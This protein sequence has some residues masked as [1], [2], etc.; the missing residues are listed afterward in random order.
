MGPNQPFFNQKSYEKQI[1]EIFNFEGKVRKI[2][3]KIGRKNWAGDGGPCGCE[4]YALPAE[5]RAR[6]SFATANDI[7][8]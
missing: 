5:L 4:P 7:I 8:P 3:Q 1:F 6:I 2:G